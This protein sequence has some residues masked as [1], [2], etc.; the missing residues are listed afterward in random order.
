MATATDYFF[1]QRE[2]ERQRDQLAQQ[3]IQDEVLRM[4]KRDLAEQIVA[5]SLTDRLSQQMG[6][7]TGP[8]P[9]D[10]VIPGAVPGEVETAT[11][12]GVPTPGMTP[13]GTVTK[14]PQFS[15]QQISKILELQTL[16]P[17]LA[18]MTTG[19]LSL[20]NQAELEGAQKEAEMALR[21]SEALLK[22]P[23]ENLNQAIGEIVKA[24]AARGVDSPRLV[25]IAQETDPEA[26]R[27]QL[28]L[29]R[30]L[31]TSSSN[32]FKERQKQL[33]AEIARETARVAPFTLSPGQIRL[34]PE[35]KQIA[36][37]DFPAPVIRS[38][39]I[40]GG[41]TQDFSFDPVT[42]IEQPIGQPY[43]AGLKG[44]GTM[45]QFRE[46]EQIK[47]DVKPPDFVSDPGKLLEDLKSAKEVFGEGSREVKIM[48]EAI[49][50]EQAGEPPKLTDVGGMRKEFFKQSG[51]MIKLRD[52]L[53]KIKAARP[54]PA[55]DV[56]LIFNYMK[57]LDPTSVVREGEQA[58][59]AEAG[60]LVD[61]MTLGLYNRVVAGLKLLP[62]QR[63]DFKAQA[64]LIFNSMRDSH[65]D[66]EKQFRD[67]ATRSKMN[68]D[69]VVLDL[70]G[71]LRFGSLELNVR[72]D[73][74]SQKKQPKK[75]KKQAKIEV[76]Y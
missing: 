75:A 13:P 55:G 23:D 50:S 12:P 71:P 32:L 31:G 46:E 10:P 27:M 16:D 70:L 24:R 11:T 68:P 56:S 41:M 25:K 51:D 64:T 36:R 61:R 54:T 30:D 44:P 57:M 19:L 40:G 42:G 2:R 9:M 28:Q 22:V 6:R 69:D 49:K 3:Q 63:D 66:L 29:R 18:K 38:Q 4:R 5:P 48:E 58:T 67:L 62:S 21:E 35:G 37:G 7:G 52:N 53:K 45:R 72:E 43:E 34:G 33:D 26:K 65:L 39:N 47:Q 8:D 17:E 20:G 15:P 73:P 1:A 60:P 74:K 14:T 59:A 76:D